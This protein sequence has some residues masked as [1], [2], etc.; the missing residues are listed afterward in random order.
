MTATEFRQQHGDPT[1]WTTTDHESYDILRHN[2]HYLTGGAARAGKSDYAE[3][4]TT[5]KPAA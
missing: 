1:T 3:A 2:D 5:L 4:L